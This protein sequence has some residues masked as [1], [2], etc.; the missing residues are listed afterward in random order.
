MGLGG[1]EAF[2]FSNLSPALLGVKPIRHFVARHLASFTLVS[3]L[4]VSGCY[5]W[6]LSPFRYD[7]EDAYIR[8]CILVFGISLF[9]MTVAASMWADGHSRE[10]SQR[11][12][13]CVRLQGES[14]SDNVAEYLH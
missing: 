4:L 10:S 7:Y 1:H 2:L 3:V 14:R 5:L 9:T 8:L 6:H 12:A 13:M 11:S